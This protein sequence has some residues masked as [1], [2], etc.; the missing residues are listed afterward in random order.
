M[1]AV[2]EGALSSAL[3]GSQATT[4]AGNIISTGDRRPLEFAATWVGG[5]V[6]TAGDN[7]TIV[8]GA[9]V[10]IDTAAVALSVTVN[11]GGT[12]IWDATAA[13]SLT[14]SISVTINSGANFDTPATG[15]VTT[16]VLTIGS[17][18]TNNGQLDF[19]TNGNTAGAGIVFTG[20]ANATFERHRRRPRHPLHDGQ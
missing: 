5:V 2:T 11:S 9:T 19:S 6:P 10:T 1:Y 12:L 16:H 4:P 13:Q 8:N 20:A 7:V 17:N 15:T 14:V 3:A 18:L